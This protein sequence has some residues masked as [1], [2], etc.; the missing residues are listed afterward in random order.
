MRTR[1]APLPWA[2]V[3]A[4]TIAGAN[5][6]GTPAQN[7]ETG[8]APV[9]PVRSE[10]VTVDV[11]VL[12]SQGNPVKGLTR[13]DFVVKEDGS[14]QAL[15]AFRE[16]IPGSAPSA[17][18]AQPSAVAT[19]ADARPESGRVFLVVF[20]DLHLTATTAHRAQDAL[21]TFLDSGVRP[22]DQVL[23]VATSRAVRRGGRIPEGLAGLHAWVDERAGLRMPDDPRTRMSAWEA[24]RVAV[25]H[26]DVLTSEIARRWR[27]VGRVADHMDTVAMAA[28]GGKTIDGTLADLGV[29]SR[30]QDSES[31][32]VRAEAAAVSGKATVQARDVLAVVRDALDSLAV[33]Q[34]RKTVLFV[35]EGFFR[36]PNE[37]LYGAL[38]DVA[39]RANAVVDFLD[40][41]E[42]TGMPDVASIEMERL[43][44]PKDHAVYRREIHEA[45]GTE[46][47][48]LETGGFVLRGRLEQG[49]ARAARE[50][51][52]YYLL[53]YEPS[54]TRADG[55]FHKIE[56]VVDRP[57]ATVRAR[58][59]Y[60]AT[61]AAPS[62]G[63]VHADVRRALESPLEAAGIPLRLA[64]YVLG[65]TREGHSLV[66]LAGS[67]GGAQLSWKEEDDRFKGALETTFRVTPAAGGE[68]IDRDRHLDLRMGPREH[69]AA[70]AE[71]LPFVGDFDLAP[72]RYVA[73][74]VVRDE[75]SGRLGSVFQD[76]E[77][78]RS[79][80]RFAAPILTDVVQKSA[81]GPPTPIPLARRTFD[82]GKPL[83]CSVQLLGAEPGGDPTSVTL[84]VAVFRP[85]GSALARSPKQPFPSGPEGE[86]RRLLALSLD[87]ATPGPYTLVLEA[88]DDRTGAHAEQR[89]SF[90]VAG[91][92]AAALP[93]ASSYHDLIEAY[94]KGEGAAAVAGLRALDP[95]RAK[96]EARSLVRRGTCKGLCARAAVLLHTDAAVADAAQG[97]D[98][99]VQLGVA[100][101]WADSLSQDP[102]YDVSAGARAWRRDWLL[103]AGALLEGRS[104]FTEA[105]RL[106]D[107]ADRVPPQGGRESGRVLL[108]QGTV[109]EVLSLLPDLVPQDAVAGPEMLQELVKRSD[110]GR[111]EA[112]ALDLY[113]R[114]L[115]RDPSLLEARLR[116]GRI[117]MRLDREKDAATNLEAVRSQAAEPYLRAL[118]SFFLGTLAEKQGRISE[119]VE[120]YR[121]AL[122][123]DPRFQTASVARAEALRRQGRS[124]A[125]RKAIVDG[126]SFP[127]TQDDDPW[128]GY[129]LGLAWRRDADLA[130]LREGLAP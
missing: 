95:A 110:Q 63:G 104:R 106:F 117:E 52:A 45:E 36:D 84:E 51:E 127:P 128:I 130:A 35:S 90:T 30:G 76:F 71:G 5:A 108:A 111:G 78:P 81:A 77:V 113:E 103:A 33:V 92:V 50:S 120:S 105:A 38:A 4:L 73:H 29:G 101:E 70:V 7:E 93:A 83:Y 75:G 24:Y 60:N 39:R 109:V 94:R 67:A 107:E 28:R 116:R 122:A 22:G 1:R 21:N 126:L 96:D 16:V 47:V 23:M 114:A 9:F 11:V 62:G 99:D 15:V 59:G 79:D 85:D 65:P 26:D 18:E 41:R 55:R 68:P 20:D 57:G 64:S 25:L 80:F 17:A 74:L 129:H 8:S 98:V 124:A 32:L 121:A 14:P 112:R 91:A 19:N 48:S 69:D 6:H 119:A 87:R 46:S 49:F 42:L 56:V 31:T 118:A 115:E 97:G 86:R 89:E 88:R 125:A 102:E 10:A 40:A 2:V 37:P 34:G 13:E 61:G 44:D 3:L 58:R 27:E 66:V 43:T 100:R 53:G 82:P 12:D 72:G 54:W 123:A